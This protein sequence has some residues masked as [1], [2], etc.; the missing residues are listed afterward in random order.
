MAEF[1]RDLQNSLY[2]LW[3]RL[4]SGSYFPPP[5]RR[6]DIPKGDGRTRP[7]GIPTAEDRLRQRAVARILRAI[8][9]PD[10]LG[11]S[12]GYR[13]ERNPHLALTALRDHIVTGK[14]R[15]VYETDIQ[16]YFMN[17]NHEGRRKRIAL[18]LADPVIPGLI[19]Q[20]IKAGVMEH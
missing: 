11:C 13:P 4:S 8:Y 6:V 16:G 1:E 9:E 10:F 17:I 5:V 14:V 7:L 2:K 18:R 3:N 12:F 19:G 15:Y 20:W